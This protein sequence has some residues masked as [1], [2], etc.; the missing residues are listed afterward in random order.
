MIASSCK[1]LRA[2]YINENLSG[3]NSHQI[4]TLKTVLVRGYYKAT[5]QQER[6]VEIIF[7]TYFGV[8]TTLPITGA[9][10]ES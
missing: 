4:Q 6:Q 10:P 7:S 8:K 5:H 1:N 2:V 3:S 9:L